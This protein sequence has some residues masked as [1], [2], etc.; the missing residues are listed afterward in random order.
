MSCE[1]S[2]QPTQDDRREIVVKDLERLVERSGADFEPD[3]SL[4]EGNRRD[5]EFGT[6]TLEWLRGNQPAAE[7]TLSFLEERLANVET[8][9]NYQRLLRDLRERDAYAAVLSGLR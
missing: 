8:E 1:D 4:S 9:I 6:R 2:R 7:G 3:G 5:V